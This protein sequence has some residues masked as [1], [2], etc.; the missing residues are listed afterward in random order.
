MENAKNTKKQ[1]ILVMYRSN[2][3][4]G[5]YCTLRVTDIVRTSKKTI[6]VD[7]YGSEKKF[8]EFGNEKKPTRAVY[9]SS[10][11]RIFAFDAAKVLFDGEKFDGFRI[12]EGK[13]VFDN[14]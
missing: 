13:S 7:Y 6:V 1:V 5:D 9:G 2:P 14:I 4:L 3:Q 12:S 8:D 11:Y 10:M